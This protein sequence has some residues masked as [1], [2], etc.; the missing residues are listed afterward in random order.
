M[1]RY[2]D[3]RHELGTGDL[4]LFRGATVFSRLIQRA[5]R[6]TWSHVAMV[7]RLPEY[8]YLALY[9]SCGLGGLPDMMSGEPR[10]G[11]QLVPL[12]QRVRAYSG[13]IAVRR[14]EGVTL[15]Q[16]ERGALMALRRELRGRTYER[17]VTSLVRAA[18]DGLAGTNAEDLSSLFCSELV[19]EAYQRL[20]LLGAG[21]PSSEYTPGDFGAVS[22]LEL[23]RGSLGHEIVLAG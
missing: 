14:L 20:G 9:E 1:T 6:S 5:T 13:A 12:S 16:A 2:E 17:S 18:Y 10:R 21:V 22:P 3:I 11:V 23:L 7:I 15:G 19:A 4:V 8:D